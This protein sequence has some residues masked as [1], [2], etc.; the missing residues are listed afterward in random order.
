[1]NSAVGSS[2]ASGLAGALFTPVQQILLGL[3]YG[4]PDRRFQS[5]ELI[6]LAAS[7]TGAV[8]R[9]L[10]RL[11]GAG[12]V[13]VERV[14]NQKYY[15]AN[16]ASPVFNEL[17]G[18]II[19]TSGLLGPLRAALAPLSGRILAAFVYGSV[20]KGTDRAASDIDLMVV[21]DGI[22]YT[23]VFSVLQPVE[24]TLARTISPNLM[25]PAE[26][27]R[28]QKQAGF[29]ARIAGQPRLFVIGSDDGL[30]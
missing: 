11:A 4:Q 23:E 7:G 27:R 15:R 14:G 25:S 21:A 8:H 22:D 18:L 20:A 28:K 17:H 26:W 30:A 19:K 16:R 1:M 24:A 6:R 9:V 3:L 12:L 29:V 2:P 10:T 13:A 5:A